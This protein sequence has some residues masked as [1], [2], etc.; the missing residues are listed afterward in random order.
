MTTYDVKRALKA[1]CAPRNTA[2]ALLEV[3][4][5]HSLAIDERSNTNTSAEY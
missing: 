4:E 2:R 5:Q 3:Q 1:L